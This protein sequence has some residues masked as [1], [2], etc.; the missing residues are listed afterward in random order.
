MIKIE[1][2]TEGCKAT[3][4]DNQIFV[5]Q[6]FN[7]SDIETLVVTQG[8]VTYSIDESEVK[9]VEAV[10]APAKT[11]AKVAPAPVVTEVVPEVAPE[12]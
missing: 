4:K 8:S 6:L 12:A 10:V 1:Q 7:Y 2:M 9:V 11:K 3:I 5:G